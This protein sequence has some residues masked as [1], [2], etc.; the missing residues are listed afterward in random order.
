MPSLK[1]ILACTAAVPVLAIAGSALSELASGAPTDMSEQPVA[2]TL[3][4][5]W[6][7]GEAASVAVA[8]DGRGTSSLAWSGDRPIGLESRHQLGEG[9]SLH[10]G[11]E[12]LA[13]QTPSGATLN[14]SD[15]QAGAALRAKLD[16]HWTA[17]VGGGWRSTT[18]TSTTSTSTASGLSTFLDSDRR[19][20]GFDEGEG[21]VWLRLSA[22][23]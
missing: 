2:S 18:S 17:G 9:V 22:E 8:L 20:G 3:S 5:P 1:T 10:F 4:Q 15:W 14:A 16:S 19:G 13:G 7:L 21:V 12:A 6:Q 23:F 11:A